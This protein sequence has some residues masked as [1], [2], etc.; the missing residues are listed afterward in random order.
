MTVC[1]GFKSSYGV[2][3][4]ADSQ[5]TVGAMK[6]D[7]PKLVIRPQIGT[8]KDKVRMLFAGAGHGPFIDRLVTEMWRAATRGP[9]ME[10][11]DV[12]GRI[13]DANIEWHRK[14][15][16]VFAQ[17]DRPTAHLLFA[18]YTP[19]RPVRLYRAIGPIINEVEDYAFVG[20][21]EELGSFLAKNFRPA[22]E[23]I[24]GDVSASLFI[25]ENVKKYVDS[26]GGDTQIAALM[27]DGSIQELRAY[28]AGQLSEGFSSIASTLY[29]LFGEAITLDGPAD[30]DDVA[31]RAIQEIRRTRAELRKQIKGR[32]KVPRRLKKS[33]AELYQRIEW[34]PVDSSAQSDTDQPNQ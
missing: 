31:K 8:R 23:Q 4:C 18:V 26:C 13:E 9:S 11:E 3:L 25:L 7:A 2:V 17:K 22:F 21:G 29:F 19:R 1:A 6:F 5:E 14:I 30:F 12:V 33:T 10:M 15:W 27:L 16:Q 34:P 20:Y 28:D 32:I 24:E